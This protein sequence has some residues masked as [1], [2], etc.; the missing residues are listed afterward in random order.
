MGEREEEREGERKNKFSSME[1]GAGRGWGMGEGELRIW[2]GRKPKCRAP[3]SERGKAGRSKG[4]EG[5]RER[6]C[7]IVL[8]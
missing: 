6:W 3:A 4:R 5:E 8:I 2:R 1:R 7:V